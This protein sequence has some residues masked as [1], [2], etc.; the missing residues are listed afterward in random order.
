VHD[1]DHAARLIIAFDSFIGPPRSLDYLW[2]NTEPIGTAMPHP[3]MGRGSGW[4]GLLFASL[5][6]PN[7]QAIAAR[8]RC[9]MA[10]GSIAPASH[11]LR[12]RL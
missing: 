4:I 2:A 9:K 10:R 12:P 3:L 6:G 5:T 1:Y 11:Q 8:L 7:I